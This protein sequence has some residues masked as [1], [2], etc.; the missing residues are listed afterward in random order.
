MTV[1]EREVIEGGARPEGGLDRQ[2]GDVEIQGG[3]VGAHRGDVGDTIPEA[4]HEVQEDRDLRREGLRGRRSRGH[5][6]SHRLDIRLEIRHRWL[7]VLSTSRRSTM[8]LA[9]LWETS[10][11]A[12]SPW[13]SG[14]LDLMMP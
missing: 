4:V 9:C 13:S 1:I 10:R 3:E 5:R 6:K 14:G 12:R 2:G 11:W 7:R 8:M